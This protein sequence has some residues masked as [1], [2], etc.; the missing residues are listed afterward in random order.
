MPSLND[1]IVLD[2]TKIFKS[3][4]L[5]KSLVEVNLCNR[6]SS[7]Q[8]ESTSVQ[9]TQTDDSQRFQFDD[10]MDMLIQDL[11]PEKFKINPSPSSGDFLEDLCHEL[12]FSDSDQPLLDL[13]GSASQ[14]N[15]VV[16]QENSQ[17]DFT[18]GHLFPERLQEFGMKN[19]VLSYVKSGIPV[20]LDSPLYSGDIKPKRNSKNVKKNC[21]VVHN[22][23]G[24]LEEA[25][26]I[27]RVNYKP[28]VISPLNL[29]PKSNGSPRLIHNLKV[30]NRFVKRGPSVK[31]LNVL[32]LAKSEFSRKTYFCKLDLSNGY[33]HL[34]IRPEDR[35]YFGFSFDNQYF[36]FN[37]L[38][39][40]YK[41]A[42][43][44][45]QAFS[46]DFVRICHERGILCKV[47]L[48]D[49]LIY[50]DS[51]DSCLNSL[52][53]IV[54]LFKYFGIKI[55]F[56]K[57]SLIPSQTIDFLG[58]SLDAR[59][60]RFTLTQDKLFKCRLIIK[61]LSRIHSIGVKLLQRILGFLNFALQLFP[62]GRSFIRPW[63]KLASNFASSRVKLNPSPL[64]HLRDVFFKGPLFAFW[65]SGV[66]QP[67]LP[68]FVDATPSR[69][70]GISG[71]GGF[72][73]SLH[74]P[75]PIFE[76]EF[77]ASFYRIGMYRT[78]SNNIHLI[79]DNLGVLFCLK[80]GSSRNLFANEIFKYLAYLWLNSPFFLNV[81]YIKSAVNPADFYT[82][83]FLNF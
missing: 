39:F 57:S 42:P 45:F 68:C 34:S 56:A 38:C 50:A 12:K 43:D 76:A 80:R 33:F 25:G 37:S 13:F 48:D 54:D 35:T 51:F 5:S 8:G 24:D 60:C 64:A 14:K 70:A 63:Y 67:S 32:E 7:T 74:A 27:E 40:G 59:K 66:A 69:V 81:S 20:Q 47:E 10:E 22:L 36:V 11:D 28:L 78:I 15:D 16:Y 26:H 73:F 18:A 23:S 19:D 62:L 77:L 1:D 29:V 44:Y 41:P 2:K 17:F 31:H 61:C 65:P 46:Q 30:L 53:F 82:R 9:F 75:C 83:Y 4:L 58:Y 3:L 79:G 52:N 71:Q 49:F 72:A 55:N 6:P 21:S